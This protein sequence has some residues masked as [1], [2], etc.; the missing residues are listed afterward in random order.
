MGVRNGCRHARSTWNTPLAGCSLFGRTGG[1]VS[2]SPSA[3]DREHALHVPGSRHRAAPPVGIGAAWG[4]ALP[5][6]GAGRTGAEAEGD[7][8]KVGVGGGVAGDRDT[9]MELR[10]RKGVRDLVMVQG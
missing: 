6:V 4:V 9:Q 3:L 8:D 10:N 1:A 5:S 7:G 2:I